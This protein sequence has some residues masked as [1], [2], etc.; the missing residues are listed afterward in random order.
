[1]VHK[2]H[3]AAREKRTTRHAG[4]IYE[5]TLLEEQ[6]SNLVYLLTMRAVVAIFV[7]RFVLST[8]YVKR[9][10]TSLST[11]DIKKVIAQSWA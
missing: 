6:Y 8:R 5:P 4:E 7:G 9:K 2:N 11:I 1:M 3:V 10:P